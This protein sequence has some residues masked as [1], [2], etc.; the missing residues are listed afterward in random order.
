VIEVA[1]FDPVADLEAILEIERATFA[2][3]TTREM[4]TREIEHSDVTRIWVARA[5][6]DV[7]VGFCSCWLV[8]DELHVHSIAVQPEE[9]RRGIGRALM[10]G[11]LRAAAAE[12][13]ARATLEVRRSNAAARALYARLGFSECGVRP[14]YYTRPVEDALVLWLADLTG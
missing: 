8:I 5:A 10:A 7:V 6:G 12:G 14:H 1:R 11:V 4:L 2:N 9:R 13:A 3:P